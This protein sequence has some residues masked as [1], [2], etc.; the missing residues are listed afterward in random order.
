MR[1]NLLIRDIEQER[2]CAV[3]RFLHGEDPGSIC[4]SL[5]R[6][7]R[8][9]YKWINRY[10][11]SNAS[12]SKSQSRRPYSNPSRTPAQVEEITKKI[13]L[14]LYFQ[15]L[16]CGAQAIH[17]EL[18]QLHIRPRPSLSTINRILRRHELMGPGTEHYEPN[19][20]LYP[21]LPAEKPNQVHQADLVG[22]HRLKG[23]ISFYSLNVV[24]VNTGRCGVQPLFSSSVQS[25]INGLW[26]I[27]TRV[28][29]PRNIQLDN[30]TLFCGNQTHPRGMGP[31]I[32]LCVHNGVEPWLIPTDEPWRNGIVKMLN[33][34][35]QQKFLDQIMITTEHK[36][37]KASLNFEHNHNRSYRYSKQRGQTPLK[38]LA[39]ICT[40]L[41]FPTQDQAPSYPLKRLESG[42]YHIIRYIRNDLSLTIFG[43]R[44]A[45]PPETQ[46]EYVVATI[47]V[48]EQKLKLFMDNKQLEEYDYQ[49][50]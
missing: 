40:K 41:T 37:R 21:G 7:T 50:S 34:H 48:K 39:G 42:R 44:F 6:S 16:F 33:I 13:R 4:A 46:Y 25:V 45:A 5:G 8:W 14:Y 11:P 38:T 47:D 12:W 43:E 3:L 36:L 31:L 10:T 32:R 18:K 20:R 26:A 15:G 30:E 19:G 28:G 35:Y 24:D 23:P 1:G 27:W 2:Q 29:I 9:L 17:R 22:P 49:L